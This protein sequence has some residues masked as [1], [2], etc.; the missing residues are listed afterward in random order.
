VNEVKDHWYPSTRGNHVIVT[1]TF[2]VLLYGTSQGC[3]LYILSA[4]GSS[5]Q[6]V[7]ERLY[8][9]DA[10]GKVIELALYVGELGR[11]A[12]ELCLYASELRLHVS[13]ASF[14]RDEALVRRSICFIVFLRFQAADEVMLLCVLPGAA[15][16]V[17]NPFRI[18]CVAYE[19]VI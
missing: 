6:L 15:H 13:E 12:S 7:K 17:R 10:S 11:Y 1:G 3:P 18:T 14:D 16:E 2:V 5:C 9:S 8:I 19:Q 4:F